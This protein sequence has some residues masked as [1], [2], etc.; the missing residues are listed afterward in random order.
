MKETP[1]LFQRKEKCCGCTACYSVCPVGAIV[2]KADEESFLYPGIDPE[3]CIRC[4]KCLRV[5]PIKKNG[6]LIWEGNNI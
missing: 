5:C 3:K 6:Q 1:I 2:M 4:M